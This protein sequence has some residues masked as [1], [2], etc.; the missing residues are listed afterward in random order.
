MSIFLYADDI[1]LLAAAISVLQDLLHVYEAE[2]ARLGMSL[3]A[4]KSMSM[5]IGSRHKYKCC[6]L[7]TMDGHEILWSN[8][9][10]Y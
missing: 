5:R 9:I 2:L 6:E 8:T 7:T 3:D 1:M 4:S 10:R